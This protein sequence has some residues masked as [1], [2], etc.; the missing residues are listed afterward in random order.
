M[1]LTLSAPAKINLTLGITGLRED[2]YHLLE[3]IMQTL[4]LAD[5]L[6]FEKIPSGIILSCNKSHIPTDERNLCF[7]AAK[8]YLDATE[9]Q[10][11]IKIDLIKCIPDGAGMGGGSSDAA[12]VL[13]AMQA[14]Y[15]A[16]V[17]LLPIAASLGADVP[18]FLKGGTVLCKGI[19]EVLQ[20]ISLPQ[21]NSLYCVVT[22]PEA[23]LST[24]LVYKL[25][26]ESHVSFSK[27]LSLEA[28]E[29]LESGDPQALFSILY[30]DLELP[31]I[32]QI[33]EIA[34]RK[35]LLLSL[36]ADAAMMT[37]SGSA[38]FGLFRNETVARTCEKTLKKK[39]LEAYF[40]T[41][42]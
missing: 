21:K 6:N 28:R 29:R 5:T 10:G 7:K 3:S 15:P 17:D 23:G 32:S 26:D 38:V 30:N 25:Y 20:P 42:L 36:G 24:P 27:P 40:C 41:L 18:F 11:G 8:R 33:P 22:K 34:L 13:K 39:G 4:S 12:Q 31:A 14:L 16:E 37:G 1:R 2:G 35:E 9:I 19:G